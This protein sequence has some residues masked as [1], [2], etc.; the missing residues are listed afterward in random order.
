MVTLY[1]DK[2]LSKESL[3][4]VKKDIQPPMAVFN[5]KS[6]VV[7]F[8]FESID[9][10]PTVLGLTLADYAYAKRFGVVDPAAL[11]NGIVVPDKNLT[12]EDLEIF[13]K[14]WL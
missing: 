14:G 8:V 4:N 9:E 11:E 1:I 10:F 3:E 13:R 12:E 5:G 6:G 7:G 2:E